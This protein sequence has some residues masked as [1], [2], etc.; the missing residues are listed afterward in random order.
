MS[1]PRLCDAECFDG[2]LSLDSY[3]DDQLTDYECDLPVPW[4]VHSSLS[5]M[6][7]PTRADAHSCDAAHALV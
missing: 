5:G 6:Q 1:S 7:V 2:D 3:R 4:A